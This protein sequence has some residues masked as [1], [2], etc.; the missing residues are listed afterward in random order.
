MAKWHDQEDGSS[1]H[2]HMSLWDLDMERNLFWDEEAEGHMSATMRHFLAGVLVSMPGLM[3]LYAPTINSY[4][5]Y[6]AGT[7]TP[8]NATWGWDN[9]TCA[10]RVINNGP[11][12]IRIENRVPGADANFYLVFAAMLA[13]GLYGIERK[14]E[15]GPALRGNAYD[16]ATIARASESGPIP[17]LARNLTLATDL[18]E[19]SEV[20]REYFGSEFVEHFA[21]TRRWEVSE[22]ERAVTNWERRRYF[23]LI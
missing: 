12:A 5:R 3:A 6:V 23:E 15:L 11:R 21:A 20:A 13:G 16:P 7:W 18:F 1:G 10:V 17:S 14:L 2:S 22:F 9:R 4:K 19:Q 8:L